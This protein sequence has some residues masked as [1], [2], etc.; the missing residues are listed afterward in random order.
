MAG[1]FADTSFYVALLNKADDLHIASIDA[2]QS[3]ERRVQTTSDAVII[4]LLNHFSER[5][6]HFRRI[7]AE[8]ADDLRS[9]PRVDIVPVTQALLRAALDLYRRRLDKGY[10]LTD[11]IAM[12]ICAERK[13]ADLLSHDHHFTQEGLR[14]LL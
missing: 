10:S 5:G 7:A 11:C 2:A 13:I 6:A 4:E 1:V 3:L 14:V 8:F 12:V 9:N